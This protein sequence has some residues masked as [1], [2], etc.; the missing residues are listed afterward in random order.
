LLRDG[1]PARALADEEPLRVP[2]VP[3]N[4]LV[5]ERVIQ[6]E[7]G[8]TQTRDRLACQQRGIAGPRSNKRDRARGKRTLP[9]LPRP[10]PLPFALCPLPFALRSWSPSIPTGPDRSGQA[11]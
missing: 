10:F 4:P 6:D 2:R 5:D 9:S 11:R 3:E 7:I 8:R 1:R